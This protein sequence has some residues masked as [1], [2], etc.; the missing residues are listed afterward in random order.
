MQRTKRDKLKKSNGRWRCPVIPC[1]LSGQS[2]PPA[3]WSALG[4]PSLNEFQLHRLDL[5]G[6]NSV[7]GGPE[8]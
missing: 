3:A 4:F 6:T 5:P 8:Q 7:S 2:P 1:V